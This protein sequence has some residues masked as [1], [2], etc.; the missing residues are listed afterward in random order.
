MH[1]HRF[2]NQSA[3]THVYTHTQIQRL[4]RANASLTAENTSLKEQ[5]EAANRPSDA[6]EPSAAA[7]LFARMDTVKLD[8][9]ELSRCVCVCVCANMRV[10]SLCAYVHTHTCVYAYIYGHSETE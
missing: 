4:E 6:K 8:D 5:L 9:A 7:Q 10:K 1:T 2:S 3:H